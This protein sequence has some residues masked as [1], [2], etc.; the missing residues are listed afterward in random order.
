MRR[1]F[2]TAQRTDA[3]RIA[4]IYAYYVKNTTVSFEYLPPDEGEMAERLTKISARFPFLVCEEEGKVAGYAYADEAF[5]RAAYRWSAEISVY[6]D[7]DFRRRGIGGRLVGA[8]EEICRR[9]G[10]RTMY[11]LV[12]GENADS[13]VF[14]ESIG[15]EK[16]AVFKDQGYKSGRWLDVVWLRKRLGGREVSAKFPAPV[17]AMSAEE[18]REILRFYE[19]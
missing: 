3:G 6:V 8:V 18:M 10:Y 12:T 16:E 19:R 7:R 15:Y 2:R 5:S 13:L 4:D 14:H 11:A 1:T 17:S 9:L